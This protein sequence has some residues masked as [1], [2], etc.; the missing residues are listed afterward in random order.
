VPR[1][2]D[3]RAWEDWARVDPFWA[4]LT[5][6][7]ARHGHWDEDEFFESGRTVVESVLADA[8]RLGVPRAHRV[9]VDFGC[10]VGRLTRGLAAHFDTAY[11]LDIAPTMIEQA[12]RLNKAVD[13]C[14]FVVH[15]GDNLHE[16][17]TGDVDFLCSMLVLQH[18]PSVAAIEQYLREFVRVLAPDGVA[19]FQLPTFVPPAAPATTLRQ[20]LAIRRRVTGALRSVGVSP[21][22]LYTW[23]RWRPAM[24]MLA[25]SETATTAAVDDADGRI[26]DIAKLPV[27]HGGVNSSLYFVGR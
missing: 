11:G 2:A 21:R 14:R 6:P 25:M 18:L 8:S 24:G 5:E 10:G 17:A 23:L 20:R 15:D 7:G 4:I 22:V 26:L 19:V 9:A 3:R 1:R 12:R 13:G 27:D 16:F